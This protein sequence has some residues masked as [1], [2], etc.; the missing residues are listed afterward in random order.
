MS[1]FRW[2][3]MRQLED[4]QL[5][6]FDT[7]YVNDSRWKIIKEQIDKDFPDGKFSFLDIG[8]GN[9][10][11]ADKLLKHYPHAV[12]TVMDNSQLLLN[13][14]TTNSRKMV[15]C[16]SVQNLGDIKERYDLICFNWLLHHLVGNSYFETR[17]NISTAIDSAIP[18]LTYRGRISIFEN[19][20]NGLVIDWLPGRLIF[21]LTSSKEIAVLIKKMG[22]NTAGVGV[23]FLSHK[24]WVNT[25]N[26]SNLEIMKYSNDEKWPIPLPWYLFLHIKSIRCGHFWL[27]NATKK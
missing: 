17:N 2:N 25:V 3:E 18:L 6:E 16:D 19:M 12:G 27:M 26:K 15:I 8:G 9:G 4:S 23:C 21:A 13:K 20:Y 1:L 22:A 10:L 11:F 24:Q 7:E 5:Q 14:N